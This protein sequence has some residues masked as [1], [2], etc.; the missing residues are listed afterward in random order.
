VPNAHPKRPGLLPILPS[1]IRRAL[2]H[3]LQRPRHTGRNPARHLC[4]DLH[5]YRSN[6]DHYYNDNDDYNYDN[7]EYIIIGLN[8]SAAFTLTDDRPNG[9]TIIGC[10]ALCMP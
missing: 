1:I 2:V 6:D 9:R 8:N 5:R 7:N 3:G 10:N 4:H